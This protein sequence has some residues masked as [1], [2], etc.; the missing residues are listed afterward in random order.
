MNE[1]H[2]VEALGG[3]LFLCCCGAALVILA[4]A[5]LSHLLH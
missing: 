3:C 1:D 5:F 2:F 4:L